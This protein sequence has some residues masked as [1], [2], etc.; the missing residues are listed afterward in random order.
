MIARCERMSRGGEDRDLSFDA[1]VFGVEPDKVVERAM[2]ERHVG[3]SVAEQP[4]L[5]AD[6]TQEDFDWCRIGFTRKHV[7]EL[8]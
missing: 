6:L 3:V 2:H 5:L 7:E 4:R 1:E 8:A